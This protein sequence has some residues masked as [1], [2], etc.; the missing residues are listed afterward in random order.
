MSKHLTM[1]S[2]DELPDGPSRLFVQEI[3]FHY[4]EAK[5]PPLRELASD[6]LNDGEFD[7]T[8]SRETI[9][10][11]LRGKAVPTRWATVDAVFTVLCRRSGIAK[12]GE[13]YSATVFKSITFE[14]ALRHLW[15]EALEG[16][17]DPDLAL[18]EPDHR[19]RWLRRP[20]DS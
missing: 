5:R 20:R 13:R 10:Q 18:G 11:M 6:V 12:D 2:I 15:D 8:A 9:R 14:E 4:R 19:E 16:R 7:C 1:P 17:S 3:F